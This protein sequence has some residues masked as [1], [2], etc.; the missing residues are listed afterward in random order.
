M[1]SNRNLSSIISRI[2]DEGPPGTEA[3]PTPDIPADATPAPAAESILRPSIGEP[4]PRSRRWLLAGLAFPVVLVAGLVIFAGNYTGYR[5]EGGIAGL[6]G[7]V[8]GRLVAPPA[9][10]GDTVL[11]AGSRSSDVDGN[12]ELLGELRLRQADLMTRIDELTATVATLAET[13]NR[14][15]AAADEALAGLREERKAAI[16]TIESRLADLQRRLAAA[17]VARQKQPE[18][19][20]KAQSQDKAKQA[21]A[22]EEWVVNVASSSQEQAMTELAEKLGDQGITVERQ[23][24]TIDGNLMYRLRVPGFTTST[25]ARQYARQLDKSH[26]LHGA[27]ISRR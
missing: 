26:A 9:S 1:E 6:D 11:P 10:G 19:T 14:N 17:P 23:T 27:W 24:L 15:R 20:A 22:G 8:G 2:R 25:E 7:S 13:M 21:A 16:G 3:E 12:A 4:A 18:P 5:D